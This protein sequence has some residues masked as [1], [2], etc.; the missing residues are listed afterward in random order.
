VL[1]VALIEAYP[2]ISDARAALVQ[3]DHMDPAAPYAGK[4]TLPQSEARVH[5]FTSCTEEQLW[6]NGWRPCLGA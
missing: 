4:W 1:C 2:L 3:N 5:V 6:A